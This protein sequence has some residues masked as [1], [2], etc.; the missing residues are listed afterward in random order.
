MNFIPAVGYLFYL[1]TIFL[2]KCLSSLVAICFQS[3][4][5][6]QCGIQLQQKGTFAVCKTTGRFGHISALWTS[7]LSCLSPW[8]QKDH[9]NFCTYL[10][11]RHTLPCGFRFFIIANFIQEYHCVNFFSEGVWVAGDISGNREVR[12]SLYS[13]STDIR[14]CM[15]AFFFFFSLMISPFRAISLQCFK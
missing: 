10:P 8:R 1:P 15:P 13:F 7:C 3:V 11:W 14:T 4:I 9:Q 2:Y 5:S 6:D 12:V